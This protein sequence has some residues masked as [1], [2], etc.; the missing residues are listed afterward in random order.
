MKKIY[1]ILLFI[2]LL[3][4]PFI[5][6]GYDGCYINPDEY[7]LYIARGNVRWYD[8]TLINETE[9][10]IESPRVEVRYPAGV[11]LL[12]SP[13]WKG[14]S[15]LNPRKYATKDPA[16]RR[17][18]FDLPEILPHSSKDMWV[19][20][21]ATKTRTHHFSA[22][23]LVRSG[24]GDWVEWTPPEETTAII[25]TSV[26]IPET[27]IVKETVSVSTVDT[28]ERKTPLKNYFIMPTDGRLQMIL[29]VLLF[30]LMWLTLLL[31]HFDIKKI[32]KTAGEPS[33][34]E[35]EASVE[36]VAEVPRKEV[37]EE[38]APE[39]EAEETE[40]EPDDETNELESFYKKLE[41]LSGD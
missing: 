5:A 35:E 22:Q 34:K 24:N 7:S 11:R 25:D 41:E 36:T 38:A 1:R 10:T 30:L 6:Y 23:L 15:G 28:V 3:L 31:I 29:I 13:R 9:F 14:K 33:F 21:V 16:H 20:F 26:S 8:F 40:R 39:D 32:A 37:Q 4:L 18:Y 27:V 2:P 12:R 19:A 17:V